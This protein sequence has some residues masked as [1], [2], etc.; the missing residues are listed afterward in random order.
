MKQV[1]YI[2]YIVKLCK[3][4]G[5]GDLYREYEKLKAKLEAEGLF[6]K[7]HK[8]KIPLMPKTI[9]VLTSR[10]RSSY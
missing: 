6:D 10:N 2:K 1:E 3:K 9:G 7:E 4:T 5:V 8:K